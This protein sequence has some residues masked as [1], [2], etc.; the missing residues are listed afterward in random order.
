MHSL[1]KYQRVWLL[2]EKKRKEAIEQYDYMRPKDCKSEED[3]FRE[4]LQEVFGPETP[5][6]TK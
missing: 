6:D 3:I 2:F 4:V 1:P 5:G